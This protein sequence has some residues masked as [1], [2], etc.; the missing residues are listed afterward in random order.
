MQDWNRVLVKITSM[1]QVH[2]DS[3]FFVL[4]TEREVPMSRIL[5]LMR[6]R[7]WDPLLSLFYVSIEIS[8]HMT[9][10]TWCRKTGKK[11]AG[12]PQA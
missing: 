7:R 1:Q 4:P 5:Y 8:G 3:R 9:M 6:C 10:K 12:V 2:A 11:K